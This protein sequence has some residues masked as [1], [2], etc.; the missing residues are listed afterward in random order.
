[1]GFRGTNE[2]AVHLP[3]QGHAFSE[4][5]PCLNKRASSD[6]PKSMDAYSD[7]VPPGMPFLKTAWARVVHVLMAAH[8]GLYAYPVHATKCMSIERMPFEC[9]LHSK[10][11]CLFK[12]HTHA[13]HTYTH[14]A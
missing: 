2:S 12:A 1:M 11:A 10:L 5:Q 8:R 13:N 6:A 14:I 7:P 4:Q 9:T 3:R